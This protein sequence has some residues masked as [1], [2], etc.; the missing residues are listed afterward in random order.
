MPLEEAAPPISRH[1]TFSGLQDAWRQLRRNIANAFRLAIFLRVP[2]ERLP[3]MW[4]QVVAFVAIS[5]AMPLA[6]SLVATGL[7]GEIHFQA[8]QGML[9][10]V[11]LMLCAGVMMAYATRQPEKSLSI[12]QMLLMIAVAVDLLWFVVSLTMDSRLASRAVYRFF[13]RV[14][15]FLPAIWLATAS[16]VATVR[17]LRIAP[18]R[19]LAIALVAVAVIALPL[20]TTFR[21][22]NLWG[23]SYE[24]RKAEAES[25][26]QNNLTQEDIFYHQPQ[27]LE[28]ELAALQPQRPGL[29]EVFFIGMAGHGYQDVFRKEVEAVA[30]L[31]AERFDAKGHTIRLI[32]NRNTVT[33]VPIASL[34]S[35]NASLKRIATT[36]DVEEDM[37]VLFLT[38][39]GSEEHSFSLDLYPMQ[40]KELDPQGLRKALDES[41]IKYRVVVV[42]ACYSGSFIDALKDDN[43][44]V[45]TAS[46]PDRNSFGCGNENDWTYFGK[47][48][49]DEALRK[50]TSFT[51]AFA[52]AKPVIEAREKQAGF[53]PSDPR[54][55]LG[56]SINAKL[57]ALQAQLG[58][59]T[60]TPPTP[61]LAKAVETAAT[62]TA[63]R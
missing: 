8:L 16:L 20:A 11:S 18:R 41:G 4:W 47:A 3:V 30:Q 57:E 48:Y 2:E 35:L 6:W 1:S 15:F 28:Q 45:I 51:E 58:R 19:R 7:D 55:S 38:S 42:S 17:L 63:A 29:S 13:G 43:T 25:Y 46:A 44:L 50:T 10:H 14:A 62:A 56:T 24:D 49:F 53:T 59:T 52:L 60:A 54:I 22:R 31:M 5:I 23:A 37:L 9:F 26:L 21:D 33:T 34:T 36:M 32:N 27:L 39:H 12:V 40:F 61:A